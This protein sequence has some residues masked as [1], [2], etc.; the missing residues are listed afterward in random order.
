MWMSQLVPKSKITAVLAMALSFTACGAGFH[1]RALAKHRKH[2]D[3]AV[4]TKASDK[5]FESKLQKCL[6]DIEYD[7]SFSAQLD[8]LLI[9]MS[10]AE[11]K[12]RQNAEDK[13]A[14][15]LTVLSDQQIDQ[16]KFTEATRN[17]ERVKRVMN[18]RKHGYWPATIAAANLAAKKSNH[19]KAIELYNAAIHAMHEQGVKNTRDEAVANFLLGDL[20][21]SKGWN[22]QAEQVYRRSLTIFS[23]IKSDSADSDACMVLRLC[24]QLTALRQKLKY[25]EPSITDSLDSAMR[26]ANQIKGKESKDDLWVLEKLANC[27]KTQKRLKDLETLTARKSEAQRRLHAKAP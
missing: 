9:R 16:G 22:Q 6:S 24:T 7:R 23:H 11:S 12:E 2:T 20:Y 5:D 17:L 3:T 10:K 15:A 13:L 4:A 14:A 8:A 25:P 1:T 27:C 18:G 21:E 19:E 26:A